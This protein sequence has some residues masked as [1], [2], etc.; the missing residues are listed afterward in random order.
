MGP[1]ENSG[2]TRGPSTAAVSRRGGERD[3]ANRTLR[4]IG[5]APSDSTPPIGRRRVGFLSDPC[6][7]GMRVWAAVRREL[8]WVQC[9]SPSR[10]RGGRQESEADDARRCQDH[11]SVYSST[12][13]TEPHQ[14]GHNPNALRGRGS[15]RPRSGPAGRRAWMTASPLLPRGRCAA[16]RPAI[17]PAMKCRVPAAH[18]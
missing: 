13:P 8:A 15:T 6:S 18:G 17:Q 14:I 1:A 5:A 11:T 3:S 16:V 7:P 9:V 10:C 2:A 12:S 4:R